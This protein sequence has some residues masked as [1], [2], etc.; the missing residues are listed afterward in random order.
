[1]SEARAEPLPGPGSPVRTAC[2]GGIRYEP[3]TPWTLFRGRRVYFCLP[4]C[5]EDFEKDPQTSCL[6]WQIAAEGG[7]D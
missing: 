2:G 3:G 6:A 5:K 4:A 1:M 7:E